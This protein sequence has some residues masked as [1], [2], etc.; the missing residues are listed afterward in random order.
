MKESVCDHLVRLYSDLRKTPSYAS[1]KDIQDLA[2]RVSK[3]SV[4]HEKRLLQLQ[5]E[6]DRITRYN[7]LIRKKFI[8]IMEPL[9]KVEQEL[10]PLYDELRSIYRDLHSLRGNRLPSPESIQSVQRRVF[11][12]LLTLV[13]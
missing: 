10:F 5:A 6:Q 7:D 12:I 2:A 8:S 13:E 11:Y 9:W 3:A 4:R 1:T